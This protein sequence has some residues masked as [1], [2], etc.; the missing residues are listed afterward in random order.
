MFFLIT[1]GWDWGVSTKALLAL[2][3]GNIQCYNIYEAPA[4]FFKYLFIHL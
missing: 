2:M 3:A 1:F 4:F